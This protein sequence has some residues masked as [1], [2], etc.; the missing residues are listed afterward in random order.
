VHNKSMKT[1]RKNLISQ[2]EI[3]DKRIESWIRL[4]VE[5][6]PPAGWIK[7]IRGA[8]GL[9]TRQLADLLGV[10]HSTVHRLEKGEAKGKATLESIEKAARAMGCKVIYAIVPDQPYGSLDAIVD[11]KAQQLAA[12]LNQR[13][14]HT[15]ELEKQGSDAA[16][17]EKQVQRLAFE[18]KSKMDIRL[19]NKRTTKSAGK[20]N[21]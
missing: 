6:A 15:M 13:V 11:Q 2:R 16:D 9:N 10:T 8:L 18:L 20:R 3:I 12:E 21:K 4:R 19:W 14:G 1:N 17:T 7:A 5:K